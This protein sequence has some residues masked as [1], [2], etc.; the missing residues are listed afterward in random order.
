[1]KL[2]LNGEEKELAEART[3]ADLLRLVGL[4]PEAP[5]FAVAR[6]GRVVPRLELP[7]TPVD[8]GDRIEVVRAVQG[9]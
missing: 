5:G 3:L 2:T 8:E 9:G 6:N 4:D 1:M 7:G